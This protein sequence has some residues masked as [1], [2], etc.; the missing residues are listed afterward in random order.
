MAKA[1]DILKKAEQDDIVELLLERGKEKLTNIIVTGG[2]NRCGFSIGKL[3][4]GKH[5]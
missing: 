4:E 3:N 2:L 1:Q 5:R